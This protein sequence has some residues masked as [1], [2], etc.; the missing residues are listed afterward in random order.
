[1]ALSVL[2]PRKRNPSGPGEMMTG[3]PSGSLSLRVENCRLYPYNFLPPEEPS[4]GSPSAQIL[5]GF[6]VLPKIQAVP[7]D[8]ALLKNIGFRNTWVAQLIKCPSLAQVTIS[9]FMGSS[10]VSGS[11]LTA[12]NLEPALDSVSP[13]L[14]APP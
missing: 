1:M 2:D 4:S 10:V 14:S 6:C 12:R 13:S 11:V 5:E 7:W 9:R 8:Q 3:P